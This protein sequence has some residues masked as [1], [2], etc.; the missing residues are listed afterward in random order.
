M[1]VKCTRKQKAIYIVPKQAV[2]FLTL[3]RVIYQKLA[4][5]KI[6]LVNLKIKNKYSANSRNQKSIWNCQYL[7]IDKKNIQNFDFSQ[8][9]LLLKLF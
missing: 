7:F 4:E 6:R 1:T 9:N 2:V 5:L 8:L 3:K